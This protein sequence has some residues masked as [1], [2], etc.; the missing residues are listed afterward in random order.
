MLDGYDDVQATAG[1]SNDPL[2]PGW[3]ALEVAE[4]QGKDV[5]KN[6]VPSVRLRLK[7]FDGP[8]KGRNAFVKLFLGASKVTTKDG[9]EMART[10]EEYD[11]A[12]TSV[13]GQMK[14]FLKAIEVTSGPAMGE[15]AE[16]VYSFY[17]VDNWVNQQFVG[18]ITLQSGRVN[19]KT[20]EEYAPQNNLAEYYPMSD[21]K[22]G[23]GFVQGKYATAGT[24]RVLGSVSV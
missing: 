20:G 23:F 3:Y 13:Q 7:V 1:M 22:K 2:E 11:K 24:A 17:N 10:Q 6:G 12:R 21:P 19:A 16:K 9:N 14:G 5:T 18:R 8:H 15:G 4:I